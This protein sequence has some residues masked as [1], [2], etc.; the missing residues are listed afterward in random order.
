MQVIQHRVHRYVLVRWHL[1][2]WV[3]DE[4]DRQDYYPSN[5]PM[6]GTQLFIQRRDTYTY[7]LWGDELLRYGSTRQYSEIHN[8]GTMKSTDEGKTISNK[9]Q[10]RRYVF[11]VFASEAWC[12]RRQA[13]APY[14]TGLPRRGIAH[15]V[16]LACPS[17]TDCAFTSIQLRRWGLPTYLPML[18]ASMKEWKIHT[19][20]PT[21]T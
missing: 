9:W 5:S 18:S 14:R 12:W 16:D 20:L 8:S 10:R 3:A 11:D 1:A 17:C 21:S 15:E 4:L 6:C 13:H 19:Y 7:Y 2:R